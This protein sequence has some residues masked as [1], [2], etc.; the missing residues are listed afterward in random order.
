MTAEVIYLHKYRAPTR[1]P[2][3]VQQGYDDCR[4][5][6]ARRVEQRIHEMDV[7]EALLEF[8][9][10]MAGGKPGDTE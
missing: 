8:S 10:A 2:P 5:E 4:L 6:F 7:G 1:I 3:A 9:R